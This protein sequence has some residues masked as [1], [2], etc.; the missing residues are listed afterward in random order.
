MISFNL[1]VVGICET[2]NDW[3]FTVLTV[4][5][6][7]TIC[8]MIT[9][10]ENTSQTVIV[11]LIVQS[12]CIR[13]Q[14]PNTETNSC[15]GRTHLRRVQKSRHS[16][17][18]N[19]KICLSP[20]QSIVQVLHLPQTKRIASRDVRICRFPVIFSYFRSF[21]SSTVNA[22]NVLT[23]RIVRSFHFKLM[24]AELAKI[25]IPWLNTMT[26]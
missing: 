6:L 3:L 18:R 11:L 12:K 8:T 24:Y 16:E 21:Y 4:S 13:R 10:I 14:V 5:I 9:P 1:C 17:V 23:A 2:R 22:C 26:N 19:L 20:V 25:S 15:E 7:Q